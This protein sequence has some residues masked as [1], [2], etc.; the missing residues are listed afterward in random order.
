M[1]TA[2]RSSSAAMARKHEK[3]GLARTQRQC[4]GAGLLRND[5][6][7]VSFAKERKKTRCRSWIGIVALAV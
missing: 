5:G 1:L 6:D 7:G 4:A 3:Q 2:G